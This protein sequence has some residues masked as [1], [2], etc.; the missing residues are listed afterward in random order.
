[1][2]D[3]LS[4]I[5]NEED[6]SHINEVFPDEHLYAVLVKDLPWYADIVNYLV[7]EILPYQLSHHKKRKFLSEAKRY[8]WDDP[9]LFRSCA[10]QVIRRCVPES[11]IADILHHY[12]SREAGGHFGPERTSA[13]VLQCG[14]YWPTLFKDCRAFV[15]SCNQCQRSGNISKKHEMPQ[16]GI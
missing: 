5:V 15:L 3:H 13:K 12:Q 11:E 2:A 9:H 10:D 4:R 7:S 6:G 1:M 8:F 16:H 14:F